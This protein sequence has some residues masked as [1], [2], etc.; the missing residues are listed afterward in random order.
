M[1]MVI[2]FLFIHRIYYVV[3]TSHFVLHFEIFIQQDF[4]DDQVLKSLLVSLYSIIEIDGYFYQSDL[5]PILLHS[6]SKQ[7]DFSSL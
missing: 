1:K 2:S 6:I 7:A 3:V 4:A 5:N